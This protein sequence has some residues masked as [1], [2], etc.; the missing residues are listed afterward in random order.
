MEEPGRFV[1]G[2]LGAHDAAF[3]APKRAG[4]LRREDDRGPRFGVS[5]AA[6]EGQ[7]EEGELIG[8]EGQAYLGDIDGIEAGQLIPRPNVLAETARIGLCRVVLGALLRRNP[9]S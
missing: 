7:V 9:P 4:N 5:V 6:I 8:G 3:P 1:Q 2:A